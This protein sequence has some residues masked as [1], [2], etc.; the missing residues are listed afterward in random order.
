MLFEL[1]VHINE[2]SISGVEPAVKVVS[3]NDKSPPKTPFVILNCL[4][5]EPK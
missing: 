4:T 1:S 2:E 5:I 3:F